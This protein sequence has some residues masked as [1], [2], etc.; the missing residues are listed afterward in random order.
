MEGWLKNGPQSPPEGMSIGYRKMEGWVGASEVFGKGINDWIEKLNGEEAL[1]RQ[2]AIKSIGL[3]GPEAVPVL[4]ASLSDWD[5]S[6]AFWGARS[7]GDLGVKTPEVVQ[8]LEESLED[9]GLGLRLGA[10]YALV[11]LNETRLAVPALLEAMR[12]RNPFVRLQAI[13]VLENLEP[14]TKEVRTVLEAAL[15]DDYNYI[16]RMAEHSLGG[17]AKR[18]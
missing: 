4:L 1:E 7:L 5:D 12:N 9:E 18:D 16:V 13:G 10:A 3:L 14:K 15:E 6:V 17:N 8:F 11:K 2:R